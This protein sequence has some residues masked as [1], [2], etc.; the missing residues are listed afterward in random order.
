MQA[1]VASMAS[2]VTPTGRRGRIAAPTGHTPKAKRALDRATPAAVQPGLLTQV[3]MSD[4]IKEMQANMLSNQPWLASHHEAIEDHAERIDALQQ[5]CS[6]TASQLVGTR[7]VVAGLE[8]D[9]ALGKRA[10][11]EMC[12]EER[13]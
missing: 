8:K 3:Q 2:P 12:G 10:I 7:G 4:A 13:P 9:A 6:G 1:A 5:A 11:D